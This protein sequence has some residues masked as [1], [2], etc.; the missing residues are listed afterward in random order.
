LLAV[1]GIITDNGLSKEAREAL[2][3]EGLEVILA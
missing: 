1:H 3:S 2:Q